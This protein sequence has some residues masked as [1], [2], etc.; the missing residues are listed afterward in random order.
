MTCIIGITDPINKVVWMGGD[1]GTSCEVV[2]NPKVFIKSTN[3]VSITNGKVPTEQVIMGFTSSWRMGQLL[4]YKCSLPAILNT[5]DELYWVVAKLIPH[6]RK[7]FKEQ[8]FT[9]IEN[10]A[11]EAGTFLLGI[12]GRLFN[13]YSNFQAIESKC[14]YHAIGCGGQIALGAMGMSLRF[15]LGPEENYKT[16]IAETLEVV[17]EHEPLIQPP[18]T[19]LNI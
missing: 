12:R 1:S 9:K 10:N 15:N 19:I 14:G 6:I 8:G 17:A 2:S 18:W 3:S 13:I 7:I 4:Q 16:H 5:D 11:E